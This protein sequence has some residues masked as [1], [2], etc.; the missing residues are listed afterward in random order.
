MV[1]HRLTASR[2]ALAREC[3]WWARADAIPD[4]PGETAASRLGSALHAAAHAY[5]EVDLDATAGTW[6]LTPG[7]TDTFLELYDSWAAWWPGYVG[8][9]IERREVPFAWDTETWTARE[10]PSNGHRDYS[11]CRPSEVPCTV[12]AALMHPEWAI[13]PQFG[14]DWV[15]QP[16]SLE[17][18][19]LKTSWDYIA[20]EDHAQLAGNGLA[21]ARALGF[22][23][24]KVTIAR[25]QP[26]GVE[27]NSVVLSNAQLDRTALDL[28]LYLQRIPGAMPRPGEH[29]AGCPSA[30]NCPESRALA[31]ALREMR[32]DLQGLFFG[33]LRSDAQADRLWT[34]LDQLEAFVNEQRGRLVD[35]AKQRGGIRRS[36][37]KIARRTDI[38]TRK[39][40]GS[41]P[42]VRRKLEVMFPGRVGE[43][44]KVK[45]T[46][47]VG[48]VEKMAMADAPRGK[49]S[50]AAEAAMT[51]LETTG[52]VKLSTYEGWRVS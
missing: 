34:G 42:A 20:A 22:E 13:E 28:E 6:R 46:V 38:T 15:P 48:A 44:V 31:V 10:L 2:L 14:Q 11:A 49:K 33:E 29:C 23:S 40:D 5:P 30:G 43:I 4:R 35:Y 50:D 12:D 39:I 16:Q 26:E 21:V 9:R 47:S 8:D 36:S 52:G 24:V 37:G 7:E 18:L 3:L 17:V 45:A 41:N 32:P 51:E 1:A 27:V 19:D 25:I